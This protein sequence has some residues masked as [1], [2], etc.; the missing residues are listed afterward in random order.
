[1][2]MFV[3]HTGIVTI[4]KYS[5]ILSKQ[6]AVPHLSLDQ[7]TMLDCSSTSILRLFGCKF[8]STAPHVKTVLGT[9]PYCV[10]E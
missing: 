7:M 6:F 2:S 3:E 10:D 1:M 8:D 4:R 9:L 5:N